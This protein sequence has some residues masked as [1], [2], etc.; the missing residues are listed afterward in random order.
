[1]RK[2]KKNEQEPPGRQQGAAGLGLGRIEYRRQVRW[3]QAHSTRPEHKAANQRDQGAPDRAEQ[4]VRQ[5]VTD[6][7]GA[8]EN[9]LSMFKKQEKQMLGIRKK[10][11]S[12][13]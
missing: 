7:Q 13:L 9:A 2:E 8:F 11:Y 5:S 6:S 10:N 1:M 3:G 12:E 4:S